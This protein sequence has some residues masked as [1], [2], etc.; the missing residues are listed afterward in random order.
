[1]T[2]D[3]S[4]PGKNPFR[5]AVNHVGTLVFEGIESGKLGLHVICQVADLVVVGDLYSLASLPSPDPN[6]P[7]WGVAGIDYAPDGRSIVVSIRADLWM[8]HLLPDNTFGGIDPVTP[9]NDGF[10]EWN[11]SYSPD[12]A[13]VA[14]TGGP[15]ITLS[16]GVRNPDIY[17]LTLTRVR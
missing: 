11:P 16:D 15:L 13:S 9:I 5:R 1:M 3:R 14:Y 4:Y 17:T 7:T 10:A 8:V 6:V 2:L 12:G